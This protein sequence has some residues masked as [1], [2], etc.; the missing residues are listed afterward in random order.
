[1]GLMLAFL[2]WN[3]SNAGGNVRICQEGICRTRVFMP[4][5]LVH[6]GSEEANWP[7]EAIRHCVIVPGHVLGHPFSVLVV[8]DGEDSEIIGVPAKIDLRQ[9]AE[10]LTS[11]GVQVSVG[12][13]VPEAFSRSMSLPVAFVVGAVGFAVLC[14]SAGF[15]TVRAATRRDRGED[16]VA[17]RRQDRPE[18]IPVFTR[19]SPANGVPLKTGMSPSPP[20][21]GGL[22]SEPAAPT[23]V[24]SPQVPAI[25]PPHPEQLANPL[26]TTPVDLLAQIDFQRDQVRGTW[27]MEEG[28]SSHPGTRPPRS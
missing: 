28:V 8:S 2:L 5:E 18:N 17:D 24:P 23:A 9:L 19:P 14:G 16:T 25:A 6:F 26:D 11:K 12:R 1:M 10:F 22:P 20:Q 21:A 3:R 27:R 7:Y 13:S 15:Y 4:M